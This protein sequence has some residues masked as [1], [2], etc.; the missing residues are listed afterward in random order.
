MKKITFFTAVFLLLIAFR[1]ALAAISFD[2]DL[3][4]GMKG[5]NDVINL[6]LFFASQKIYSGPINGNFFSLTKAAVRQFQAD[7][8]I[9]PVSGYFGPLTRAKAN[10]LGRFFI[11]E[12]QKIQ[13]DPASVSSL[14]S[15]LNALVAQLRLLQS[16]QQAAVT[17]IGATTT[18]AI[19]APAATSSYAAAVTPAPVVSVNTPSGISVTTLGP[20]SSRS[21]NTVDDVAKLTFGVS[22]YG[23]AISLNQ[24]VLTIVG[25]LPTTSFSSSGASGDDVKLIDSS[26]GIATIGT[27]TST[28]CLSGGTCTFSF[29]FASP[30]TGAITG[31]VITPGSSK[32]FTVRVNS[33]QHVLAA[34]S[35]QAATLGIS[36]NNPGDVTYIDSIDGMGAAIN[37]PANAVPVSVNSVSYAA[38]S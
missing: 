25:S 31:Y 19:P 37:L 6:Q 1:P 29:S 10:L 33:M 13:S 3:Y 11:F 32:T 22:S 2:R 27:V 16:R 18:V 38:G 7:Q 14:Q 20:N 4:F 23:G 36:I 30:V 12:T 21:K 17:Q 24:I 35:G 34:S 28:A 9:A 26:T 5:D 8:N 15:E